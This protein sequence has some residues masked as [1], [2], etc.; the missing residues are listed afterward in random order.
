MIVVVVVILKNEGR[1][2]GKALYK[3]LISCQIISTELIAQLEIVT[4]EFEIDVLSKRGWKLP[5]T[6]FHVYITH[7]TERNDSR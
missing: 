4:F 7:F 6:R 2:F 1:Y 5:I 3:G